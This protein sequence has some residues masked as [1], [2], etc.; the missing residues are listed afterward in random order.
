[1]SELEEWVDREL[2]SKD[3]KK[4]NRKKLHKKYLEERVVE[5]RKEMFAW[6]FYE[7]SQIQEERVDLLKK[8]FWKYNKRL[9]NFK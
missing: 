8:L 4:F 1:M 6:N 9:R 2:K 7:K 5:I 3:M